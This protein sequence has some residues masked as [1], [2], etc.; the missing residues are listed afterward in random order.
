[1]TRLDGASSKQRHGDRLTAI[2]EGLV[3]L[4]K[5][6]YGQAPSQVKSYYQDDL[7]VCVLR[8]GFS[9]I[10]QTLLHSGYGPA[11]S[12]Q[13]AAF[14][15]L[16]RDRFTRVIEE[17]VGR[18]VIGAMSGQE[19]AVDIMCEV[20]LLGAAGEDQHDAVRPQQAVAAL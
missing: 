3:A 16:M 9:R 12:H 17:A 8:G 2:S 11:V 10:E 19:Q 20:F 5:E 15:E 6:F 14:Q 7:V 1:M 13:R 4:I 18:P